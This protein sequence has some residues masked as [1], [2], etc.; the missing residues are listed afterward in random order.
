VQRPSTAP[1]ARIVSDRPTTLLV[2]DSRT[3]LVVIAGWR[4]LGGRWVEL[5]V[6]IGVLGG[7]VCVFGIDKIRV[8]CS[9][10]KP[11]NLILSLF[12]G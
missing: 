11:N 5:T 1:D 12:L 4:L 7:F 8:S 9:V 2:L 6:D 10:V 3:T